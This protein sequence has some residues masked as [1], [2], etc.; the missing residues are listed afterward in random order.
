MRQ[1]MATLELQ[2]ATQL[3]PDHS[4]SICVC[5]HAHAH[6]CAAKLRGLLLTPS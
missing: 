5:L 3:A 1:G 4:S 6:Y 2:H